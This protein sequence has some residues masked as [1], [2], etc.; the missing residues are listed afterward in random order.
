MVGI[1]VLVILI[2]AVAKERASAR[3]IF[4][5]FNVDDATGIQDKAYILAV[6]LL[7][8]QYSVIGYDASAHMVVNLFSYAF[9]ISDKRKLTE[10]RGMK[11]DDASVCKCRQ[12][13]RRTLTGAAQ[14]GS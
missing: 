3:F 6:G 11:V 13:R 12:R 14:W 9:R 1:L 2:P 7:M 10:A 4:T 5:H 8:S